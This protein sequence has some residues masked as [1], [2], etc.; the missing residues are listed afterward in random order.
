M[1]GLG[2]ARP[3]LRCQKIA[4]WTALRLSSDEPHRPPR[5]AL[6]E[7]DFLT[8]NGSISMLFG[9]TPLASLLSITTKD[10]TESE[11]KRSDQIF[12]DVQLI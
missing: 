5:R 11:L 3:G 7:D 9:I 12:I 4:P 8:S 1:A 10:N 6:P 2:V